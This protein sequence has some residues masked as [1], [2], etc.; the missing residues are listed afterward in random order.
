LT[1]L[2]NHFGTR[3]G[4]IGGLRERPER[5]ERRRDRSG[6]DEQGKGGFH[7]LPA[8]RQDTTPTQPDCR[9][10]PVIAFDRN[11]TAA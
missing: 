6:S 4:P 9:T 10:G 1:Q 7:R 3:H 8:F 11:L 5:R 2:R